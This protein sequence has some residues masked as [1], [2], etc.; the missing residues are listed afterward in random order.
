M[1]GLERFLSMKPET[2]PCPECGRMA[3]LW[4]MQRACDAC[5]AAH[6]SRQAE[7]AALLRWRHH[8]A[9]GIAT[10]ALPEGFSDFRFRVAHDPGENGAAWEMAK[11]STGNLYLVGPPG[12]GKT[13]LAR[14]LLNRAAYRGRTI[15]E[16]RAPAIIRAALSFGAEKAPLYRGALNAAC[17]LLD[18]LDKLTLRQEN[19]TALWE[20]LDARTRPGMRTFITANMNPGELARR[21]RKIDAENSSM[22]DAALNRLHPLTVVQ[23]SGPSK[24]GASQTID[25]QAS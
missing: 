18:D 23:F 1:N 22:A 15:A 7:N 17:F 2:R 3:E 5:I 14:C 19:L 6:D 13:H 12:T 4:P 20:I 10:G 25:T 24:R 9:E 11:A 16:G 8:I 21:F